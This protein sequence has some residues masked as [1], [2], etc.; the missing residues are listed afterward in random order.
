MAKTENVIRR[1]IVIMLEGGAPKIRD[2]ANARVFNGGYF[3]VRELVF[4]DF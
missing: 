4:K 3:V 1:E 2:A